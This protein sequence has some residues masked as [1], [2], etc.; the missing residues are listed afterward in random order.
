VTAAQSQYELA[1]ANGK[2]D[3]SGTGLYTHAG[4]HQ[5]PLIFR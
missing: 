4:R 3:V 2:V 5:R 1:R